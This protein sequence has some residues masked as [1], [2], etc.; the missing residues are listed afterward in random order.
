MKY[1]D[2]NESRHNFLLHKSKQDACI[3]IREFF[4]QAYRWIWDY[5]PSY[6]MFKLRSTD[7][8]TLCGPL[9]KDLEHLKHLLDN[10]FIVL[11][12]EAM[13]QFIQQEE[14]V[15]DHLLNNHL[16]Y[17]WK[18]FCWDT[19]QK[20]NRSAFNSVAVVMDTLELYFAEPGR[21]SELLRTFDKKVSVPW[22]SVRDSLA[23]GYVLV[24][25]QVIETFWQGLA[26]F[27]RNT[28]KNYTITHP[29]SGGCAG[30]V[31]GQSQP[32]AVSEAVRGTGAGK[33]ANVPNVGLAAN[34]AA[35]ISNLR[36]GRIPDAR[37]LEISNDLLIAVN[38][39]AQMLDAQALHLK[40]NQ[41]QSGQKR[42][43][44]DPKPPRKKGTDANMRRAAL[45]T[46]WI[47]AMDKVL[48]DILPAMTKKKKAAWLEAWLA[49]W[50]AA[51]N[52]ERD[53]L[54]AQFSN[55][56]AQK[57]LRRSPGPLK[58]NSIEKKLPKKS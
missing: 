21:A 32:F 7:I 44:A 15:A 34:I 6:S 48:P 27:V 41:E 20:G 4:D 55:L 19:K 58:A 1:F 46:R 5:H 25:S 23:A 39:L 37:V 18:R 43:Q 11:R 9:R 14:C 24:P 3:S 42:Q 45:T 36:D 26:N 33:T 22:L 2:V 52:R 8:Y 53:Q 10:H 38:E 54:V 28:R 57:L 35:H 31:E 50:D 51:S 29:G 16:Y 47:L 17:P 30:V 56:E 40:V 12:D 49:E 13:Q